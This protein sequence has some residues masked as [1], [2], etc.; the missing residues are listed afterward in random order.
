MG[1]MDQGI[2]RLLQ[3]RPQDFL[4]IAFPDAHAE[5]LGPLET[6]MAMEPQLITDTLFHA[7]LYNEA[8]ILDIE[9]QA[10]P[11]AEMSRRM[12]KYGARVDIIYDLPVLSIVLILQPGGTVEQPPYRRN[13]GSIPIAIW[14]FHNI[15]IY[16][17]RGRDIIE[18]GMIS[19]MPLVPFMADRSVE[20][21]AAAAKTI[22]EQVPDL[23][24]VKE[25]EGLLSVFGARFFGLDA[26]KAMM[27]ALF[28]SN[29]IIEESPVYQEALVI[30][31]QRGE[32]RGELQSKRED[33]RLLLEKR[34]GALDLELVAA[35]EQADLALLKAVFLDAVTEPLAAV[36]ARLVPPAADTNEQQP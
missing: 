36:R 11:E 13:I 29:K 9:A 32:Q 30:G 23:D 14:H 12:F 21:V 31:E 19:L 10:Y 16:N 8:C 17:L 5:F 18:A 15:E 20:I 27:E 28:M 4:D 34:F 22:K 1:D 25:L 33:V 7:R 3:L 24:Q 26:I 6:D 2:K 35:I